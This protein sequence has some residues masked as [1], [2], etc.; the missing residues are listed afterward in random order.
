MSS[1]RARAGLGFFMAITTYLQEASYNP[2]YMHPLK[3]QH[4]LFDKPIVKQI[5]LLIWM[6]LSAGYF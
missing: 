5:D 2:L 4:F 1:G 3:K 6:L